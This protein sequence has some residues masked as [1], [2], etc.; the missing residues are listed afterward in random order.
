MVGG[1]YQRDD[2]ET[3]KHSQRRMTFA[4][5]ESFFAASQSA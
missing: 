5:R 3:C 2:V 1:A 4:G